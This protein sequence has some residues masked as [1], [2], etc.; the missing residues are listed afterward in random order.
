MEVILVRHT[1]P[2]VPAGTCY[3]QTDVPLKDSFAAEAAATLEV[4]AMLGAPDAVFTSPLSRCVRLAE[5]CGY[6]DAVRDNRLLEMNFGEWEMQRYE[7]IHD[8]Y[9]QDWYED[10]INLPVPGGESFTMQYQRVSAFL[11][12]LRQQPFRRVL[13]FAHGGV[14]ACAKIFAGLT[15]P[16][17]AFFNLTPYG[18]FIRIDI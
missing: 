6:P 15:A 7:E 13:I 12:E 5:F 3:G 2:D 4:L 18:G 11:E 10:Y 16:K 9:I 8:P 1:S 17:E 14:L